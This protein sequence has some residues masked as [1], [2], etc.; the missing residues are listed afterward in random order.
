MIPRSST[1][2]NKRP[3]AAARFPSTAGTIRRSSSPSPCSWQR[4]PTR[5]DSCCGSPR[6]LQPISR[7]SAPSCR[8]PTLLVASAF[9]ATFVNIGHGQNGFFTAALLGGALH[10]LD[11]RPLIAGVLIGLLAYK[12]QFGMLIPIAL[13]AAWRWNTIAAAIA[14]IATLIAISFLTLGSGVWHAFADSTNFTQTIVLEQGNTGWE[15]IQS[16]FSAARN[17][18][19]RHQN[20]LRYP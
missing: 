7:Q 20:R 14:T 17:L 10:L 3:L 1:R 9:P 16:V 8:G 6:V 19:R 18:G 13:I 2:R 15:K 12:P 5:G 11:R 4:F